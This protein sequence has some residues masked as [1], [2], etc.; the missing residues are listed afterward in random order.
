[1]S[2]RQ[3]RTPALRKASSFLHLDMATSRM[4]F[5]D[6]NLH[7]LQVAT[8][9]SMLCSTKLHLW[10]PL[11]ISLYWT[12]YYSTGHSYYWKNAV[13]YYQMH[14]LSNA[15]I[16]FRSISRKHDSIGIDA[17]DNKLLSKD[18]LP[19]PITCYCQK[20]PRRIRVTTFLAGF[21]PYISII[22]CLLP[23]KLAWPRKYL[24]N[25]VST[26]AYVLVLYVF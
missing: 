4:A 12:T 15:V 6:L 26:E 23:T 16:C 11:N 18:L 24:C 7:V 9:N 14:R 17:S 22:E 3:A 13:V 20:E 10:H 2:N 5:L 1:M 19:P 8:S 25:F 21:R